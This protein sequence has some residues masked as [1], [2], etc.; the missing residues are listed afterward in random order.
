MSA[1][2]VKSQTVDNIEV[3]FIN[4]IRYCVVANKL[5]SNDRQ[6]SIRFIH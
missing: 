4:R 1:R 5:S 2:V 3:I 6:D